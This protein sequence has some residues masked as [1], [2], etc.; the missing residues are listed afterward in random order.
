[1]I[2]YNVHYCQHY[3]VNCSCLSFPLRGDEKEGDVGQVLLLFLLGFAYL[4]NMYCEWVEGLVERENQHRLSKAVA[5][6]V[7]PGR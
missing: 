2:Y 3:S 6:N 4:M 1:M 5:F 7:S